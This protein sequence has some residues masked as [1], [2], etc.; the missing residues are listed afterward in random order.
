MKKSH[1]HILFHLL[2]KMFE[3]EGKKLKLPTCS[4]SNQILIFGMGEPHNHRPAA[5]WHKH[6]GTLFPII[7]YTNLLFG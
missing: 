7:I 3:T 5:H 2:F 1:R 6:K 4:L